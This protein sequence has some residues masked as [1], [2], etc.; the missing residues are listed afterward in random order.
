MQLTACAEL[1]RDL[2]D[3]LVSWNHSTEYKLP[4]FQTIGAGAGIGGFEKV[5]DTSKLPG[6]QS[7][8]PSTPLWRHL[9]GMLVICM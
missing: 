9:S 1:P 8:S 6:L 3:A 7:I 2:R 5:Y 4:E